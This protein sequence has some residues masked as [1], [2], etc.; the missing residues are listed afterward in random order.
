[1]IDDTPLLPLAG[2]S[3]HYAAMIT[4]HFRASADIFIR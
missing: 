4:P 2:M 1:M 3:F